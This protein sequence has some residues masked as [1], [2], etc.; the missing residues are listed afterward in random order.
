MPK[1][2]KK[3]WKRPSLYSNNF[4]S[5][6]ARETADI[7]T[8]LVLFADQEGYDREK[9]LNVFYIMFDSVMDNIDPESFD[10][11]DRSYLN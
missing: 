8:Q 5:V 1:S 10:P 6:V 2:R 7:Y 4:E 3:N 9:T 11:Y